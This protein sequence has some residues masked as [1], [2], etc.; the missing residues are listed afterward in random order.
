MAEISYV[1]TINVDISGLPQGLPSFNTNNI[2]IFTNENASFADSYKTYVSPQSVIQDFGTDSLTAKMATAM[3]G[4]NPNLRSGGGILIIA[5]YSAT[6]GTQG[7]A[8]TPDISANINNFKTVTNGEFICVVDGIDIKFNKLDFSKCNTLVDIVQV[9]NSTNPDVSIQL[10]TTGKKI[11]FTSKT[12][13][14]TST[15]AFKKVT[16][17][18]GVDLLG[19]NYLNTNAVVPTDGTE[20]TNVKTLSEKVAEIDAQIFFGVVLDTVLRS[21]ADIIKNAT[22]IQAIS[23]KLYVEALG[24]FNAGKKFA[25]DVKSE[26]LTQTRPIVYS[27]GELINSKIMAAAAASRACATDYSGSN[28]CITMNLKSLSGIAADTNADNTTLI[29][30]RSAGFDIY[31]NTGGL[32]CYYSTKSA[33]GYFD[34]QTGLM[35]FVG[36]IEI[37]GFNYLR[38]V[39]TKIA[40]TEAGMTGLKNVF[41]GVCEK[42]VGNGWIGTGLKWNSADTFGDPEDFARNIEEHGYYIYSVPIAK[43]SQAE[44]EAR[45]APLVQIAVKSAGAIHIVNVNGAMEA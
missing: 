41:G 40:Q 21:E 37:A 18:V 20:A 28:T 25:E 29:T 26:E 13:G 12:V 44:R 10:D 27:Y 22:E 14:T 39:T 6:S 31:G 24:S 38:Q 2:C 16:P 30:A 7:Q 17:T 4:V 5:P 11:E 43:Q 23:K 34:D 9:L 33:G 35:A 32:S 42:Y 36:D 45:I 15:I 1:N 3:F 8:V 19:N